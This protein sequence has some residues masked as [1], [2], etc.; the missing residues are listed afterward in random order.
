[1][2]VSKRTLA[3][4]ENAKR[5]TGPVSLKGKWR[6]SHNARTHGLTAQVFPE[7]LKAGGAAPQDDKGQPVNE[8]QI[9]LDLY[10]ADLD[11]ATQAEFDLVRTLASHQWHLRRADAYLENFS[12]DLQTL[13]PLYVSK[14]FENFTRQQARVQRS[15]NQTLALF[16]E[17]KQERIES[18]QAQ[19]DNATVLLKLLKDHGH[20][21]YR[22]WEPGRNGFDFSRQ[23]IDTNLA[24]WEVE[25]L[26]GKHP[27]FRESD[28]HLNGIPLLPAKSHRE[29]RLKR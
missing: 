13:D 5:S 6:S 2:L 1:M 22:T 16:H 23:E 9:L 24:N 19:L 12:K 8:F 21:S 20:P 28:L 14:V 4:R 18:R 26:A 10:V 25:R 11:P 27:E 29:R 15:Y 17:V 7:S 3:N